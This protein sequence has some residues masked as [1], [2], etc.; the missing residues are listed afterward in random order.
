MLRDLSLIF[1][2]V[3]VVFLLSAVVLYLTSPKLGYEPYSGIDAGCPR[4][5]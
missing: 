3:L 4:N 5:V 1:F 2:T